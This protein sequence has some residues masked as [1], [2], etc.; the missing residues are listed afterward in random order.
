[1]PLGYATSL[2]NAVLFVIKQD[3]C[4]GPAGNGNKM[5]TSLQSTIKLYEN[6]PIDSEL[7][8]LSYRSANF[9]QFCPLLNLSYSLQQD[10][11]YGKLKIVLSLVAKM[12]KQIAV[13]CSN[14][15]LNQLQKYCYS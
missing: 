6:R 10:S 12:F 8:D 2:V 5:P 13:Q 1:M 7:L 14:R 9:K 3:W 11:A 4:F 15:N